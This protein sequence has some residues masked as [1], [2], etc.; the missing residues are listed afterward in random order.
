[1]TIEIVLEDGRVLCGSNFG[2]S[3]MLERIAELLPPPQAKLARWLVDKCGDGYSIFGGFDLRG[4]TTEDREAFW[5]VAE[6][7]LRRRIEI[8]GPPQ[9]W[10]ENHYSGDCLIRLL[11]MRASMLRGEPPDA[12]NDSVEPLDF[13][14]IMEDLDD[15]WFPT[16]Q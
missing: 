9:A 8:H 3:G 16:S 12:M 4:L 14:G 7:D 1:M 10:G 15:I 6:R 5:E 13:D 11:E 2:M